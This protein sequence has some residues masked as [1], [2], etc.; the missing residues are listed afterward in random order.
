MREQEILSQVRQV[1][2]AC[3]GLRSALVA[4]VNIELVQLNPFKFRQRTGV[5][6]FG[7]RLRG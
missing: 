5:A 4:F 2:L 1:L 6:Q 3:L 7:F